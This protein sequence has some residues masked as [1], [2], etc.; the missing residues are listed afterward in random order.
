M[1][2]AEISL[3]RFAYRSFAG[4]MLE[5]HVGCVSSGIESAEVAHCIQE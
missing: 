2:I 5:L 3:G 1:G 4:G